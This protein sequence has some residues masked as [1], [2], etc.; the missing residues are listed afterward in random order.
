MLLGTLAAHAFFGLALMQDTWLLAPGFF[1]AL[2][3][4][5]VPDLLSDQQLGGAIA[6]GR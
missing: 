5:W 3:L 6:G 2:D 1:K 4:P